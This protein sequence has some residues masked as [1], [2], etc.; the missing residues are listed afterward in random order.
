[1]AE[2]RFDY[3]VVLAGM[4]TG[5]N[6][7]EE[8]LSAMPGLRSFGELFNPHF[9]GKPKQDSQLGFTMDER[10]RDPSRVIEAL[11]GSGGG[12]PGFRLF[13][14]HDQR[15]I[16][17]VLADPRAAKIVLIR[18][19]VDSYVS[20]KIARK[21]GQW[22]LGDMSSAR[23]AKVEFDAGEYSDFLST[24]SAFQGKVR[25]AL[26]TTGQTAFHIDYDD[27]A[28]PD[29]IA[30][31]GRF[32]GAEGPPDAS[33]VRA[34]VQNPV[35]ATER[36]TN[37]AEAEVALARLTTP[38][39]GFIPSY[40]PERGPG[41]RMFHAC[42]GLPLLYMP[43]RGAG[44]DP[45]PEWMAGLDPAGEVEH[46]MTQK[47]VR[48]WMRRHPGHR[49]FTVLRHP[50]PRAYDAFCRNIL[51]PGV[52]GYDEIKDTLSARYGVPLPSSEGEDDWSVDRQ[53]QSFL[54]FLGF[55]A[56]NLGGQTSLRVDN[57]WASQAALLE[58]IARFR[59]PDRVVREEDLSRDLSRIAESVGVSGPVAAGFSPRWQYPL[60]EIRTGEIDA[61]CEA[62]YRRDYVFFG[63]RRWESSP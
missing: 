42:A 63:F 56:D 7:L 13:Y 45:V 36:L 50:L 40:E 58:A 22:W 24:L 16:D 20:L 48:K 15:V 27:L 49:A 55:L 60:S 17:L 39:L 25:H 29:V 57:S 19:P 4:R 6:L 43:I 21:T 31:L 9:F 34:K 33:K 8:Y 3:F 53:R 61:V 44:Q 5:S 35:P 46:G 51:P 38:D 52:E 41:M 37:A 59:V 32:L 2:G 14:D 23:A 11:R 12:L 47:D 62:A 28:D 54:A 1:M 30:G 26:Q 10:D 18:R